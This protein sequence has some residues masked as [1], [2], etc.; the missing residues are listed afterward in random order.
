[1]IK[2]QTAKQHATRRNF[3]KSSA[4]ASVAANVITQA[5]SA[6]ARSVDDK[7]VVGIMEVSRGS[8]L[9]QQFSKVPGVEVRY[10]CDIDSKRLEKFQEIYEDCRL[11]SKNGR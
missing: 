1:M 3:L 9:A 5:A 6:A 10:I 11:R 8:A 7:V 4:A 2:S